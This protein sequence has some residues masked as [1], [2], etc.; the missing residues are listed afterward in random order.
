MMAQSKGS[1][2]CECLN[3]L[4]QTKGSDERE[5]LSRLSQTK[6]SDERECLSRLSQTKGSDEHEC[7]QDE[8][9]K[10]SDEGLRKPLMKVSDKPPGL[11]EETASKDECP[12][13]ARLSRHAGGQGKS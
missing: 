8:R 7:L 11:G 12:E 9:G 13:D 3:R 5:C 1:D 10:S 4:S 6:G 2:E